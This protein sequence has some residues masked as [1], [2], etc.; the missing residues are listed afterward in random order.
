MLRVSFDAVKSSTHK[1]M[2][3]VR[4]IALGHSAWMHPLPRAG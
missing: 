2:W 3:V 1:E 4:H